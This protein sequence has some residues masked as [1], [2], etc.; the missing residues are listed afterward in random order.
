MQALIN[1]GLD[2]ASSRV[3][4]NAIANAATPQFSQ[5]RDVSDATPRDQLRMIDSD[6]R[7][8]LL[9]NLDYSSENPYQDRLQAHPGRFNANTAD[10]PYKGAQPVAPVPP[11][12]QPSVRGG[13]YVSVDNSV[14]DNTPI[15]TVG[16]K[17]GSKAGRHLRINPATKAVDAVPMQ[18]SSPQGLVTAE[19]AENTN[20]NDIELVVRQL[21]DKT[22]VLADG[23]SVGTKVWPDA[24]VASSTVFTTWAQ[25]NLMAKTSADAVLSA[26]GGVDSYSGTW[27]PQ[28]GALT[29]NPTVTY[30][31]QYGHY[32]KIGKFVYLTGAIQLASMASSGN[33]VL[34]IQ[35]IPPSL[36]MAGTANQFIW[37][38]NVAY[39]LNWT[40]QGPQTC[41]AQILTA[42]SP[43]VLVLGYHLPTTIGLI[44]QANLS[45]TAYVSFAVG[46]LAAS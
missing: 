13:D 21:A 23:T 11:L 45:A 9:T 30:S 25:Q 39:M 42:G 31:T 35:N 20:S 32:F 41:Y 44:T 29:T 19:I 6:T 12:S 4:A 24:A 33:G 14:Q 27:T 2:P 38:G 18:F 17:F 8:Y 1:G 15:A 3:I 10:H 36:A 34:C 46:Y 7:K 26:L 5:S 28:I 16:M 40:T 43:G 22:V 37:A